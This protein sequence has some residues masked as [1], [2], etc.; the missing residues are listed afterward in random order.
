LSFADFE[1]ALEEL[2]AAIQLTSAQLRLLLGAICVERTTS[3]NIATIDEHLHSFVRELA[4]SRSL[5]ADAPKL[6]LV[7]AVSSKEYSELANILFLDRPVPTIPIGAWIWTCSRQFSVEGRTILVDLVLSNL[8]TGPVI[9]AKLQESAFSVAFASAPDRRL[10]ASL[11]IKT[12]TC[13]VLVRVV[14]PLLVLE[15]ESIHDGRPAG[16]YST[17]KSIAMP[18]VDTLLYFTKIIHLFVDQAAGREPDVVRHMALAGI[19]AEMKLLRV[20]FQDCID[21]SDVFVAKSGLT[22]QS[23]VHFL[24]LLASAAISEGK[25]TL[26]SLS[27]Y[28]K[29]FFAGLGRHRRDASAGQSPDC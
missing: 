18:E 8:D 9:W 17:A 4:Q 24:E 19:L 22:V 6:E 1:R 15:G 20:S 27:M 12:L 21:A 3:D 28:L 26:G 29:M 16:S 25:A 2:V 23:M 5:P 11:E 7:I 14:N 13:S 10:D